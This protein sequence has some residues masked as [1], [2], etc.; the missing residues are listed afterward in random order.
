MA[1][2][3][4]FEDECFQYLCD[5]YRAYSRFYH[6][7]GSDSTIPDIY[8]IPYYGGNLYVEVKERRAQC[9]QFVLIP[10]MQSHT[11]VYSE[12]NKKNLNV[13][14]RRIID[15]MNEDFYNYAEAG[16]RG[17]LVIL[18]ADGQDVCWNW[19]IDKYANQGVR[20]II[21]DGFLIFPLER[22][23]DYFDINATYRM[24]RSGSRNIP[25][26]RLKLVEDCIAHELGSSSFEVSEGKLYVS[27]AINLDGRHFKL[28]GH[29]YMFSKQGRQYEIRELSNT[30]HLNVIFSIT[31]KECHPKGL[32]RAG[33]A[34]YF[35]K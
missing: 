2:W 34:A 7:G 8:V 25:K 24:K 31:L 5:E 18:G 4:K 28:D 26:G 29:E 17:K 10:D 21:T 15:R 30:R 35:E 20:L 14:S 3:E 22:F 33:V 11:F 19:I 23:K 9:G 16:T 27:S 32:D 13:H 6:E 1:S 12:K